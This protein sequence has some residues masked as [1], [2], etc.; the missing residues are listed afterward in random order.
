MP[1]AKAGNS[2]DK[3]AAIARYIALSR[4][5]NEGG[6]GPHGPSQ[7]MNFSGGQSEAAA[8]MVDLVERAG[9]FR[10]RTPD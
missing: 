10:D 8:Q 1:D 7:R 4:W 5:E 3:D 9:R 2:D 6:A